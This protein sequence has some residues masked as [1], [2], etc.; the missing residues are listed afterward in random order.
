VPLAPMVREVS[1]RLL[2][3]GGQFKAP[4]DARVKSHRVYLPYLLF[5][6]HFVVHLY[7]ANERIFA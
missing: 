5:L 1:D 7:V 4:Q 2:A 3:K 6:Q